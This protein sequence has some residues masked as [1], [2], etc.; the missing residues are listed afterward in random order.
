[1]SNQEKPL[2]SAPNG[3]PNRPKPAVDSVAPS[4]GQPRF[5]LRAAF[6]ARQQQLLADLGLSRTV[7][8]HPGTLGDATELDWVGMLQDVLP[9]RYGVSRAFV[10]DAKERRSEQLDVVI[11]DRHFSPLLFEVGGARFIPAEGVY[12][13]FEVKQQINKDQVEYVGNKIASVRRLNRTSAPIPYAGGV[14]QPRPLPRILGGIL[15]L[16]SDWSPLFGEPL[17]RVLT[18]RDQDEALDLG[19]IL[20]HGAFEVPDPSQPGSLATSDGETSVIFFTLRLLKRLQ[21]M[22]TVPAIDFDTYAA[23]V[24]S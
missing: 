9:Q 1:V 23:A 7:A 15:T 3:E 6:I 5:D 22:A 12:A 19:C 10:V 13:V 21:A 16:D 2:P 4:S 18:A 17:R 8:D 20:R 14:Y 11:H 24:W